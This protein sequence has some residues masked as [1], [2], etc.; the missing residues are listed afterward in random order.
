MN[1]GKKGVRAR[2]KALNAK[3][4]KWGK[5]ILLTCVKV[6]LIGFIA[7]GIIGVSAGIGIFNGIIASAQPLNS[8]DVAP[9]GFSTFV[10][11]NQGN[12][13]DKLVGT[14][15]NRIPV[16]MDKIPKDLANAFVAIED[17]RFYTH[18]GIDIKAL[19]RSGYQFLKTG[20]E[21]T[22]GGSTITQQ[23]IKNTLFP[24]WVNEDNM[25]E[26]IERKIQEQYLSM[27]LTKVLSKEEVLERYMNTINL[28]QNTLGVQ[29]ASCAI[30]INP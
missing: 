5:K 18:N 27:E 25:M 20:G 6:V 24:D 8:N 21:E 26:K 17:E 22:Q 29:A 4:S 23:L 10:Y 30:S 15:S 13:I 28:G 2:Q 16:T 14:N 7:V 1:Y 12:Q 19:F 9:V 3:S 11:D